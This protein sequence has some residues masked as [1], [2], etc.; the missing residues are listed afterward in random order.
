[1]SNTSSISMSSS[2]IADEQ[3]SIFESATPENPIVQ[4]AINVLVEEAKSSKGALQKALDEVLGYINKLKKIGVLDPKTHHLNA[5]AFDDIVANLVKERIENPEKKHK[6]VTVVMLDLNY[7]KPINNMGYHGCGDKAIEY[8]INYLHKNVINNN[9]LSDSGKNGRKHIL[10]RL[11]NGDE[12]ALIM[13]GYTTEQ[14]KRTLEP[15]INKMAK[16][17][18]IGDNKCIGIDDAK[19]TY[20]IQIS[21][22]FGCALLPNGYPKGMNKTNDLATD[23]KDIIKLTITEAGAKEKAD[24]LR[25]RTDASKVDG[26]FPVCDDRD[27]AEKIIG[28][29]LELLGRKLNDGKKFLTISEDLPVSYSTPQYY[30]EN[31]PSGMVGGVTDITSLLNTSHRGKFV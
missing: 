30:K 10:T 15:I 16:D 11:S 3:L 5:T 27:N 6:P 9:E 13:E 20:P 1:M 8:L 26:G 19:R 14:A 17:S 28:R 21:A 18:I 2:Q 24:K 23:I 29:H 7:L 31:P 12:F 4:N 25:S 22:A